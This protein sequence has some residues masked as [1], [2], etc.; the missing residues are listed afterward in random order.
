MTSGSA[1]PAVMRAQ[2]MLAEE[3]D[4]AADLWSVPGWVQLHRDG[5]A[6]DE[7]NRLNP[8]DEPRT[9]VVTDV[10]EE[11]AGPFV[12]VSDYQKAVP[13]LIAP[14]VPGRLAVLGTDG[15]GR[16]DTRPAL[17]RH[18]QIDAESIVVAALAE[19]AAAGDI[20]PEVVTEAI[21]TY[22]LDGSYSPYPDISVDSAD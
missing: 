9:A 17:R 7:H 2:E 6:V 18:F 5:L 12:A 19:L 21:S 11:A 20:K 10:L 4:V 16:S 13:L 3:W 14:W 8:G 1:T 15:F 22:D